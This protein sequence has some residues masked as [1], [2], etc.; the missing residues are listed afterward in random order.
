MFLGERA[1][2]RTPC[3][4]LTTRW[5]TGY[6]LA[7]SSSA[8]DYTCLVVDDEF[9]LAV[10]PRTLPPKLTPPR[11][12]VLARTS[13]GYDQRPLRRIQAITAAHPAASSADRSRARPD[14]A[15]FTSPPPG[16]GQAPPLLGQ[17]RP[18]LRSLAAL[19]LVLAARAKRQ[20]ILYDQRGRGAIR[21]AVRSGERNI[22][23]DADDIGALR[24]ALGIRQWDILGHS[25][26]GGIAMLGVA[27]RPRRNAPLVTVDAVGPTSAWMHAAP[28]NA[29][30]RATA[31]RAARHLRAHHVTPLLG[32][33]DPEIHGADVARRLSRVVRRPAS[34]AA[35]LRRRRA[36][37]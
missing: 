32:T 7:E 16:D 18:H 11:E 4:P 19:A 14:F 27:G 25:W 31:R 3:L 13:V 33:P 10:S 28:G 2:K 6:L 17:R 1:T 35:R 5:S 37:A 8:A 12:C 36:R 26:G 24:R 34:W 20:V 22:D 30:Q 23:D 15:V 9:A 21:G 29:L